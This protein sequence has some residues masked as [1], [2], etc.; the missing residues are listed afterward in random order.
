MLRQSRR[1]RAPAAPRLLPHAFPLPSRPVDTRHRVLFYQIVFFFWSKGPGGGGT[2]RVLG[3]RLTPPP[4]QGASSP[5]LVGG[6]WCP[7]PRSPLCA[8][9]CPLMGCPQQLL[10][11]RQLPSNRF[12]LFSNRR[13]LPPE[14]D[15]T[16]GPPP[17]PFKIGSVLPRHAL[18]G[19]R[20]V[21]PPLP[22][23]GDVVFRPNRFCPPLKARPPFYNGH[24]LTAT[25]RFGKHPSARCPSSAPLCGP[26][27]RGWAA[28]PLRG[29]PWVVLE[30]PYCHQMTTQ[31]HPRGGRGVPQKLINYF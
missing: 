28:G 14:Y 7:N 31:T 3:R 26:S 17:P 29:S 21:P 11:Y 25:D 30:Y 16:Y 5:R 24:T 8:K 18:G 27:G 20:G 22:L 6:G 15:R 10:N 19:P 12:R 9:G 2:P 4:P 1:A 23:W 13:R